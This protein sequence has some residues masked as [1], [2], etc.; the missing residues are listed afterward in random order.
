MRK[1]YERK[2]TI[3]TDTIGW[4]CCVNWGGVNVVENIGL[5]FGHYVIKKT[6]GVWQ[7][8]GTKERSA[9]ITL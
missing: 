9:Q 5:P 4:V 6:V 2:S 8:K 1:G 3:A 7:P